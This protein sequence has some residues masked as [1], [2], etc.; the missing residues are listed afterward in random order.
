MEQQI[1]ALIEFMHEKKNTSKNTELSYRR[2]LKKLADFLQKDLGKNSFSEVTK[3]DL[4]QYIA[5]MFEL[6][7]APTS[8]SRSIAS[9][10]ALF[11]YLLE[12]GEV[13]E[14]IAANLKSPKIE[15][16]EPAILSKK[17]VMKLLEQPSGNSPKQIRDKAML[18]LLYAT[19][20][21]VSELINLKTTDLNLSMS[22]IV[23][24]DTHKERIIPFGTKAKEALMAY[25]SGARE[26]ML[27][28]KN[29][30]IL[31]ANCSGEAMSRQGFWKIIKYYAKKAGIEE[32][33]TPHTLRHSFAAHLVENGADLKSVQEM[34]GHSDISTTQVYLN[35][36]QNRLRE[37]YNKT[38][39]RS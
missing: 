31:F 15:K 9:A 17:D 33:I 3:E 27:E 37:V 20:I 13:K 12:T 26:A 19:G 28:D 10:K 4:E 14:D 11:S 35:M 1:D 36:T 25:L 22:F 2:D 5:H 34:L 23:C 21:R 32:D 24:H 38:H 7:A 8:V 30:E 29:S 16:K 39:P 18:E 6:N